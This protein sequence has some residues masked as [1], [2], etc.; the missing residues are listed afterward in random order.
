MVQYKVT[1]SPDGGEV[2]VEEGTTLLEAADLAGVHIDNLCGGQGVCG[3]CKVRI[4]KGTF[5][6]SAKSIS[7]LS[8]EE[9]QQ[10]Y[11]LA[12]Q[13]P[14]RNNLEVEIPV[15]AR[16][17]GEQILMEG[18]TLTFSVPEDMERQQKEDV[19]VSLYSPL[20]MKMHLKLPLPTLEDNLSD[21][22]RIYREIQKKANISDPE[23]ELYKIRGIARILRKNEM[24]I[25]ATLGRKNGAF[26]IIQIEGGDT[27]KRNFGVA[28]DIGT[29]T[30]VA[31]LIDMNSR[32]ILG[33]KAS[34][35]RQSH[36]GEDVI[37]RIIYAC[38]RNG[39]E[40]LIKAVIENIGDLVKSLARENGLELNEITA[41]MAAGNTT[42]T[43]LLLGLEPCFIRTEPYIPTATSFPVMKASE[44]WIPINPDGLLCVMPCVSSYVGGDIT[45]GVLASGMCDSSK[46]SML[47]DLGTNGEIVLGNCEW[48]VCCSASVGPAFEGGGLKCGMRATNGAIQVISI[49]NDHVDY[50]AIGNIRPRG[51][52]GSGVIDVL[53]E[54]LRNRL[55]QPD[56]KFNTGK[57]S[58]K[59]RR[60]DD[61]EEFVIVRADESETGNDIVVTEYDISN[62]IK[63]KGAVYAAATILTKSVGVDF[64]DLD[65]IYIAGGFGNYLN[66]KNAIG[67]GLLPDLPL[68][69]FRFIGN[70]SLAG[71]RMT[72]LSNHAFE[73]AHEIAEKMT[74]FELSINPDFMDEFIAALFLPH[75]N[76]Q[77]FPSVIESIR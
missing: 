25:T 59:I 50:S 30:V 14:V 74:Y 39:M 52:C 72:L 69:R 67:I 57:G 43:H 13:T 18:E 46:V 44:V 15:K 3:E 36:Y 16:L 19:G 68:E 75:T 10:G 54:L 70:S 41:A 33:T 32:E 40:P 4:K 5:E 31:Q 76:Q 58:S 71:A 26:K 60:T 22:E 17:E 7:L 63:S 23:I 55:I 11:V 2:N 61:G 20:T 77:L 9:I 28:L 8:K 6:K 27:S 47:M 37:S 12:C 65:R 49:S 42:M 24:A 38:N 21:L 66:I 48:L 45:A 35:N 56:G 51:I 34:H 29:T 64:N 1:F 73:K 53:A 62:L